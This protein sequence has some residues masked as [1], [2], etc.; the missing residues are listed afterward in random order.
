MKKLFI[1]VTCALLAGL[2]ISC[3]GPDAAEVSE[4]DMLR[5]E[6]DIIGVA[7]NEALSMVFT[8]LVKE[9]EKKELSYDECIMIAERCLGSHQVPSL[10]M[11]IGPGQS[12][13][14]EHY[15][16]PLLASRHVFSKAALSEEIIDVLSDSVDII[17]KHKGIFD[18][19]GNILDSSTDVEEKTQQLE[20]LY[21]TVDSDIEPGYE[22]EAIMNSVSTIVHSLAYWEE[23]LQE[24]EEILSSGMQKSAAIGIGG[25]IAVIDGVGAVIGTLEGFRDTEPGDEGRGWTIAG[26]AVGEAAKTSTY[27]VLAIILL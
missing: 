12:N 1:L 20:Q 24:W 18:M 6:Y 16:A 23:H 19:I 2:W 10:S 22:K 8:D 15:I 9:R 13:A 17:E 25:A 21:L 27:A 26:R 4:L 11:I 14:Y 7:H 5:E 3:A